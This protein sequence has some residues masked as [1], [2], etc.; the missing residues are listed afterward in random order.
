MFQFKWVV[1]MFS[2]VFVAP[3]AVEYAIKSFHLG[4]I[5]GKALIDYECYNRTW[6]HSNIFVSEIEMGFHLMRCVPRIMIDHFDESLETPA[7]TIHIGGMWLLF[8]I[9]IGTCFVVTFVL[10]ANAL[11]QSIK[12]FIVLY[13]VMLKHLFFHLSKIRAA[14]SGVS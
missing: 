6:E 5:V 11:H 3:R 14:T 4:Q 7:M 2:V 10:I 13:S 12:W 9:V 1:L 8:A